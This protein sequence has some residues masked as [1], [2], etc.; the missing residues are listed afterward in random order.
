MPKKTTN[1][2]NFVMAI[3]YKFG[4]EIVVENKK[5]YRKD[6]INNCLRKIINGLDLNNGLSWAS[7]VI[8]KN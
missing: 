7:Y 4:H 5:I 8:K 3:T 6:Y 2:F 1:K